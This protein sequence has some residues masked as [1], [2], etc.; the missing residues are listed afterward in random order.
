MCSVEVKIGPSFD[1]RSR[2]LHHAPS[3]CYERHT[4]ADLLHQPC[5]GDR[6]TYN[7]DAQGS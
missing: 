4:F 7:D 1:A 2:R 6:D 5:A 3:S